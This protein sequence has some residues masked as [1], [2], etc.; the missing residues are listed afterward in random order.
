MVYRIAKCTCGYRR[1]DSKVERAPVCKKCN[2]TMQYSTNWYYRYMYRGRQH[3]ISAGPLKA[4]AEAAFS[5]KKL[6]IYEKKTGIEKEPGTSWETGKKNF[7]AWAKTNKKPGTHKMYASCLASVEKLFPELVIKHLDELTSQDLET[8]KDRRKG[9]GPA[10]INREITSI[11]RVL[12][13]ATEQ[14]PPLLL[15]ENNRV[16]KVKLLKEPKSR[17]RWITEDEIATLLVNCKTPHLHMAVVIA[18]ETGLR[19][20]GCLSLLWSEIKDG[21]ITKQVKND[22]IVRV[23]VTNALREA[24]K[25][26]KETSKVM[27]KYVIPSPVEPSE[28]MKSDADIGFKTACKRAKILDFTFH[29]LRHTFATHF[30]ARTGDLRTLQEIL[31]HASI[32]MTEKYAH[33]MDEYKIKA[34]EKFDQ[35]RKSEK[36]DEK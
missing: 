9:V 15:P 29:D 4:M 10:T 5:K 19:L 30:L 7:L 17:V 25:Q 31:G 18:L 34:M 32:T 33:V 8:Y 2:A 28:H 21:L 23:P 20:D 26:Y 3:W 35:G 6:E 11:K 12:S 22:T 36:A 13:W 14:N 27:S 16:M 24:L 1:Y